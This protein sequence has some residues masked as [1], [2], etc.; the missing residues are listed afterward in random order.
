MIMTSAPLLVGVLCCTL[1]AYFCIFVRPHARDLDGKPLPGPPAVLLGGNFS[2]IKR[3]KLKPDG[4]PS[5][6]TSVLMREL[7]K[8]HGSDGLL[9]LRV[10][11]LVVVMCHSRQTVKDVLTGSFAKFPKAL[12]YKNLEFGL[13]KGLV[14]ANGEKWRAHRRIVEKAFHRSALHAMLPKFA[15]HTAEMLDGWDARLQDSAGE[16]ATGHPDKKDLVT[17]T[18]VEMTHLTLD[19]ICDTGFGYA[20]HSKCAGGES[21]EITLAI[22]ALLFEIKAR[23]KAMYPFEK[24]LSCTRMRKSRAAWKVV[25][26]LVDQ[27]ILA[28]RQRMRSADQSAAIAAALRKDL[29]YGSVFGEE[30]PTRS[31]ELKYMSLL[32]HLLQAELEEGEKSLT[33]HELCDEV[34]TF[35]G[36][37]HETTA[38]ML[39]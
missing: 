38:N 9:C 7:Y 3:L 28:Q 2:D 11:S 23:F 5:D 15:R 26:N 6:A 8:A 19:I 30:K 4:S 31:R 24:F 12:M 37:G 10:F 17:D 25:N 16:K 29:R 33:Y 1:L 27:H 20:L 36:A 22:S 35:L 14:T 21:S 34:L 13:G 39:T 32:D 18:F